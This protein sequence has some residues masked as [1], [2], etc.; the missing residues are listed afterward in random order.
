MSGMTGL[1]GDANM[2][3]NFK[4]WYDGG[5]CY[6][7]LTRYN[8]FAPGYIHPEN[9]CPLPNPRSSSDSGLSDADQLSGS[10]TA[11]TCDCV[12]FAYQLFT[13]YGKMQPNWYS[14]YTPKTA[15]GI[16]GMSGGNSLKAFVE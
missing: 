11:S 7:L 15:A 13:T 1:T 16:T 5:F 12:G 9:Q 10:C 4:T 3:V 14:S 6:N 8:C 2:P